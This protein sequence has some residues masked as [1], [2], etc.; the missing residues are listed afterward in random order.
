M[1]LAHRTPEQEARD[2][3]DAILDQAGWKVQSIKD[4]EFSASLGIAVREYR[5]DAG[6]ADYDLFINKKPV[7]VVETKPKNWGHNIT[8]VE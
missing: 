7:G 4:I 8:T 1:A 5:T 6:P 2:N 3:I